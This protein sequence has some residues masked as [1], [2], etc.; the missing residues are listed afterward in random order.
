MIIAA[1]LQHF[2]QYQCQL[3]INI[4]CTYTSVL[5]VLLRIDKSMRI[6]DIDCLGGAIQQ[7]QHF[8]SIPHKLSTVVTYNSTTNLKGK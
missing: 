2:F 8:F 6:R 4:I 5:P 3:I 7:Q 1:L